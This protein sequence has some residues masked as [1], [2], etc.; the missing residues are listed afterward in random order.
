M[1]KLL[2]KLTILLGFL[3][4]ISCN[5]QK[6]KKE[7]NSKMVFTG[8]DGEIKLVVLDPGHF[9]ASLLQKFPQKQVQNRRILGLKFCH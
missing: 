3:L 6:E 9:H 5:M 4:L 8:K 2:Y 7:E 1:K